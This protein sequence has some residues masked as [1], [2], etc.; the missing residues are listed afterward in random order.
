MKKKILTFLAV[1]FLIAAAHQIFATSNVEDVFGYA[2]SQNIG[3]FSLN[4]VS[5]N[6][7]PGYAAQPATFKAQ[8]DTTANEFTAGSTAWS[9]VVG[10]ISFGVACPIC[11]S[12]P[13]ATGSQASAGGWSGYIYMGSVHVTSASSTSFVGRGWEG[14]D[15]DIGG[16]N[17]SDTG[18]GWVD[19]THALLDP[20]STPPPVTCGIANGQTVAVAPTTGLCSDASTPTVSGNN[21]WT[22]M[23]GTDTCTA[24]NQQYVATCGLVATTVATSTLPSNLCA[25]GSTL[26]NG[27]VTGSN[28]W[29]WTCSNSG[30]TVSCSS[31]PDHQPG[32]PYC[33]TTSGT[34]GPAG[35][36]ASAVDPTT[37][38]WTCTDTSTFPNT[39]ITCG[40][41]TPPP[42]SG[43][44]KPIYK[45]N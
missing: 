1:V 8:F 10:P 42:Q 13:L 40:G 28:P 15:T 25:P 44:L 5:S 11:A 31:I 14:L 9:P 3:C 36:V 43:P 22:W 39:V 41:I 16:Q 18:I 32:V 21:P 7:E 37:Q 45:E 29:S 19:F 17:P 33:G 26:V 24:Q 2:C 27:S 4:S 12:V 23:C 34:C 20:S 38:Q 35:V 6:T 30:Q